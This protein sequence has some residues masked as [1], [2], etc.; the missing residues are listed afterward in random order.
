MYTKNRNFRLPNQSKFGEDRPLVIYS[1]STD[2]K[3][4]LITFFN[5]KIPKIILPSSWIRTAQNKQKRMAQFKAKLP[6][7]KKYDEDEELQYL[8]KN[9][10]HKTL[11]YDDWIKWVWACLGAGIGIDKIHEFSYSGDPEKYSEQSTNKIIE[12]YVCEKSNLGFD[13][14]KMW[15]KENGND[16][17]RDIEKKQKTLS[18]KRENHITWIDLL[19]KYHNQIYSSKSELIGCIRD[20]VAQVVSMIQGANNIFTVYSN[21]DNPYELTKKLCNLSFLYEEGGK[22]VGSV[23]LQSLMIKEPLEFPLYNKLVFKPNDYELKQNERNTFTGFQAQ[24]ISCSPVYNIE[25]LLQHIF[26]VLANSNEKY[27]LYIMSWLAQIIKTPYKPTDIFLL[28]QGDQG[29]GKTIIAEFLVKYVFGKNLS[30]STSGINSLISRFNGAVKSKLFVCCNELTNIDST[31]GAFNSA[32]DK[33]KN[34]ITDRLVQ[35]EMKGFE[36]IQIE[37]Y[38]NFMGTTNHEFTAKLEKNDR[39]YACFNVS[40]EHIKDYTY[41]DKL[42][43]CLNKEGGDAFYTYLLNYPPALMVD[44]RKIPNTEIR[45]NMINNSKNSVEHFIEDLLDDMIEVAPTEWV[46]IEKKQISKSNLYIIF[47][48]WCVTN[49]ERSYSNNIFS[50]M[51]PKSYIEGQGRSTINEKQ[52]RYIQFKIL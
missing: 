43:E 51:I 47:N 21:H 11:V 24:E 45:K 42:G 3:D 33:M 52:I 25:P 23:D 29:S 1:G 20:D 8:V 19:K 49:G 2:V 9:T 16:L 4:H 34:L 7:E 14:L 13:T 37:N 22:I 15:A 5:K 39:R 40:N 30:L 46:D 28:F 35:I 41:F 26:K 6:R 48:N 32:F 36:H 10:Q 50:R 27:Y 17:S 31:K 12:Q 18:K 44:L 38:C